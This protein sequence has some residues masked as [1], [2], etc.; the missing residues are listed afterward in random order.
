MSLEWHPPLQASCALP[1]EG[2]AS[3][4]FKLQ[5]VG[6]NEFVWC[7]ENETTLASADY[8]FN[9]SLFRAAHP[10]CHREGRLAANHH[11]PQLLQRLK[12]PLP[13]TIAHTSSR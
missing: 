5:R 6:D 7:F 12:A 8:T 3:A 11:F 2:K 1:G 13:G 10:M 9:C 4:P